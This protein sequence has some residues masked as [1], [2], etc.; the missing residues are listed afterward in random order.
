MK[1]TAV[2]VGLAVVLGA[3][4][5]YISQNSPEE[6]VPQATVAPVVEAAPAAEAPAA[7]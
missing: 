5:F 7:K 1:I 4:V 6:T 2:I 3:A